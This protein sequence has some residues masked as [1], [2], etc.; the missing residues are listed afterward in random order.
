MACLL[1][2]SDVSKEGRVSIFRIK[3]YKNIEVRILNLMLCL[4]P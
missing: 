2:N 3:Y 4:I 1:E